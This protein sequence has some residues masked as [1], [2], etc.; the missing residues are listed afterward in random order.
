[1][2]LGEAEVA[3]IYCPAD[4]QI[5]V[6]PD[7]LSELSRRTTPLGDFAQAYL[8]AREVGHHVQN[9]LG[10]MPQFERS[11]SQ[12]D[13]THG[14]SSYKC[15]ESYRRTVTRVSGPFMSRGAIY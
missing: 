2:R 3:P 12:M 1:M 6:D 4:S 13:G 5:Y 9:T 8:L 10:T 14:V 7:F 15:A 11:L